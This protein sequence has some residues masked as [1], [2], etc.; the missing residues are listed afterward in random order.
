MIRFKYGIFVVKRY[1]PS[2]TQEKEPMFTFIRHYASRIGVSAAVPI[3][4][5]CA[6]VLLSGCQAPS[7]GQTPGAATA[8]VEASPRAPGAATATPRPATPAAA[9]SASGDA[10]APASPAAKSP[11]AAAEPTPA[12]GS[13]TDSYWPCEPAD[14]PE[15]F[16]MGST[17]S[18][19]DL[20]PICIAGFLPDSDV[21]LAVTY[22]S[23][24]SDTFTETMDE[25]GTAMVAWSADAPLPEGTYTLEAVQGDLS[26]SYS[27]EVGPAAET[28]ET[29]SESDR[30]DTESQAGEPAID[31]SPVGDSGLDFEVALSGFEPDQEVALTLYVA[32][33]EEGSDWEE[34]DT[35]FAQAD[36]KGA[37]TLPLQIDASELPSNL[38]LLEYWPDEGE[39]VY[40]SF[41]V[42]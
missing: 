17:E 36:E 38:M 33:D 39:P 14:V 42:E 18:G 10:G 28:K 3:L 5:V 29:S 35:L 13:A 7:E 4:L 12:T 37:G 8:R 41:Q 27:V 31:V 2:A 1:K 26:A 15:V 32:I 19:A 20:P 23:G 11:A 30:G 21:D 24:E 25:K 9:P 6:L 22:P 16:A 40:A 34:I